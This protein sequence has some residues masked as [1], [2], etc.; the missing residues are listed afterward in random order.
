[1][2]DF[3]GELPPEWQPKWT[4]IRLDA[5]R[6]FGAEEIGQLPGLRL[7]ERFDSQVHYPELKVLLPVIQGLTR[8]LPSERISACQALD[9]IGKNDAND[10]QRSEA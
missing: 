1:M 5:R 8:F 3:V 4:Q 10:A 2:I 6:D 9:L 7:E